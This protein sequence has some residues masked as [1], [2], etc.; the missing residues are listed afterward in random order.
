[1]R[2]T[3]PK[4][5]VRSVV[6]QGRRNCKSANG[7]INIQSNGAPKHRQEA[8]RRSFAHTSS[9]LVTTPRPTPSFASSQQ[10]RHVEPC[11]FLPR[12]IPPSPHSSAARTSIGSIRSLAVKINVGHGPAYTE[13][14]TA[15]FAAENLTDGKSSPTSTHVAHEAALMNGSGPGR[16]RSSSDRPRWSFRG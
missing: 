14:Q 12:I 8:K 1:M 13:S 10:Q 11:S 15:R 16:R 9:C 5:A 4:L 7:R 2:Q 6:V 3:I